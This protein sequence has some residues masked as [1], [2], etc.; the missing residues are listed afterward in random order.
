MNKR[1]LRLLLCLLILVE[2]GTSQLGS[3]GQWPKTA[4]ARVQ[5]WHRALLSA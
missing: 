1:T 2:I 3:G 5:E 4:P